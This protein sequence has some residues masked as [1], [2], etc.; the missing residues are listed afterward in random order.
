MT[1]KLRSRD[2][3][4]VLMLCLRKKGGILLFL[5]FK[6]LKLEIKKIKNIQYGELVAHSK[7]FGSKQ[8]IFPKMGL[9]KE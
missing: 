7:Q 3:I 8:K 9:N 2:L 6:S 1:A 5:Q 4:S